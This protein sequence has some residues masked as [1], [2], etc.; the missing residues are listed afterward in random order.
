MRPEFAALLLFVLAVLV[1]P[2]III[3]TMVLRHKQRAL[4]HKER[5]AALEKG[6]DV[7][8]FPADLGLSNPATPQPY[9]L[10]GL[11]WLFAGLA[12]TFA[13]L[14]LSGNSNRPL[15]TWEKVQ[16]ANNARSSG[17]TDEE[18]KRLWE[19]TSARPTGLPIGAAALGLIP[20]AVGAAYLVFYASERKKLR[21]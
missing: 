6:V 14:A 13:L 11:I 3:A 15:T 5:M 1:G 20:S 19:D 21:S 9:M 2:G 12:I 17:A 7:P 4:M 8:T 10:R 16:L 18:V